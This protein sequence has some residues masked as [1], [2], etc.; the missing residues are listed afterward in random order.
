MLKL[1]L[2]YFDHLRKRTDSFEKTLILGKIEG[3]RRRGQQGVRW[4]DGITDT[5]DI[6]LSKLQEL[7]M[8]R[9][10]WHAEVYGVARSQTRLSDWTELNWMFLPFNL[11]I[12]L[13][14]VWTDFSNIERKFPIWPNTIV[15]ELWFSFLA[16]MTARQ[17]PRKEHVYNQPRKL[18]SKRKISGSMLLNSRPWGQVPLMEHPFC[19]RHCCVL[20][21]EYLNCLASFYS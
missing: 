14:C 10:A 6:N 8:D 11:H 3:R 19:H 9:E 2:Q 4:L 12:F 18:G 15:P 1:K 5:M 7:A 20:Y 17:R 16:V 13:K 21:V